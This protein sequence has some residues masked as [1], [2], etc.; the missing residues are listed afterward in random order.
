MFGYHITGGEWALGIVC[1][2]LFVALVI[3]GRLLYNTLRGLTEG[4]N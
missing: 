1:C 4:L 2:V 3:V